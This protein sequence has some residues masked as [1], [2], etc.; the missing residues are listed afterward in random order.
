[1]DNGGQFAVEQPWNSKCAWWY[2][3][4]TRRNFNVNVGCL[5]RV[6]K[7]GFLLCSVASLILSRRVEALQ[8]FKFKIG[9]KK[10]VIHQMID[11]SI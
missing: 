11:L 3:T 10:N 1:L 5:K 4:G 8:I 9:V 2:A 7:G 6:E